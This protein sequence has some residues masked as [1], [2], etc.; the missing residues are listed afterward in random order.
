MASV[1]QCRRVSR[2][3]SREVRISLHGGNRSLTQRERGTAL[4]V[5]SC[6][7]VRSPE[8]SML[9][10]AKAHDLWFRLLRDEL[11]LKREYGFMAQYR[12]GGNRRIF[13]KYRTETSVI[14][15]ACSRNAAGRSI[16]Q[17]LVDVSPRQRAPGE[18]RGESDGHG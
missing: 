8:L 7:I 12:N 11:S 2:A 3:T 16:V 15:L 6:E 1:Q 17:G 10:M 18:A 5:I 13:G 9:M 14:P 4:S